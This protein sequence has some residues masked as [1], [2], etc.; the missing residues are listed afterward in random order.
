[1]LSRAAWGAIWAVLGLL[2]LLAILPIDG[3]VLVW[4]H[5]G[6]GAVIGKGSYVLPCLR[7][8]R[9]RGCC[10]RGRKGRCDCCG[11]CIAVLPVLVSSIIHAFTCAN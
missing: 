8:W 6:I 10:L 4:L 3:V 2:C 5:R 9:W 7:C 1:M 11:I